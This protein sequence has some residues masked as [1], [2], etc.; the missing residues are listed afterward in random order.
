MKTPTLTPTPAQAGHTPH[1][2]RVLARLLWKAQRLPKAELV[3]RVMAQYAD[4]VP[5][6]ER[7]AR[8]AIAEADVRCL[9]AQNAALLAAL[10]STK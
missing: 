6:A 2:R 9:K 5:A 10:A 4:Q 7:L 8:L 3:R 1:E